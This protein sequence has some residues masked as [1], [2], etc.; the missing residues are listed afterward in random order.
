MTEE[1]C[2][3]NY[4]IHFPCL[5]WP[6]F[7]LFL[8]LLYCPVCRSS[9][10][11]PPAMLVLFCFKPLVVGDR[12]DLRLRLRNWGESLKEHLPEQT[13]FPWIAEWSDSVSIR[14]VMST[15][16][17]VNKHFLQPSS[18]RFIWLY[19]HFSPGN[20]LGSFQRDPWEPKLITLQ[21]LKKI[22]AQQ[23]ELCL[24]V[25]IALPLAIFFGSS[26]SQPLPLGP[27]ILNKCDL[28]CTYSSQIQFFQLARRC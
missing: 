23:L 7:L 19:Y 13:I 14:C 12:K 4:R 18:L 26:I 28:W 24:S 27:F 9:Q 5:L 21:D 8:A 20:L 16:P 15:L 3:T 10:V 6:H 2:S 17:P 22:T 11:Q 1:Y 25:S